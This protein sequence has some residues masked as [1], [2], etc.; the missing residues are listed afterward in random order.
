M[1]RMVEG[2]THYRHVVHYTLSDGK[3]RR[4]VRYSPGAHWVY[5]EVGRELVERFGLERIKPGSV[6]IRWDDPG[7]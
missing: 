2:V 7:P 6:R 3:R 5:H 4:M 1:S